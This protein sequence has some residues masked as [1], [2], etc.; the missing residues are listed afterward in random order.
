LEYADAWFPEPVSM[1]THVLPDGQGQ[2]LIVNNHPRRLDAHAAVQAAFTARGWQP[3]DDVDAEARF[4][5][6]LPLNDGLQAEVD[7]ASTQA[8]R[9]VLSTHDLAAAAIVQANP[10]DPNAVEV[11]LLTGDEAV[12]YNLAVLAKA[13]GSIQST[14]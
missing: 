3:M 7:E 11:L 2:V 8:V 14:P 6:D 5:R 4:R 9:A 1:S 10:D 13:A 12:L